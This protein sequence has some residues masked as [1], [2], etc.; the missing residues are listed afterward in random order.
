M[1]RKVLVVTDLHAGSK[2]SVMPDE[3][4]VEGGDTPDQQNC[5]CS[6]GL[7]KILYKEWRKMCDEVGKVDSCITLGDNIDGPNYKSRGF[8]LWTPSLHQQVKTAADLLSE[9]KCPYY[10]YFGVQGSGY[11]VSE[12][13]S[14]DLGVIDCLRG[15][16]G[17]DLT[18]D[19][20]DKRIHCSHVIAPSS[21]PVS[22]ATAPQ[23]EI[24]WSVINVDLFGKLDLIL[25]GHRHEYI[26]LINSKG[27]FIAVPGWKT[28]DAFLTKMGLKA[29]GH[30]IGYTVLE[31][32]NGKDI[33]VDTHVVTLNR[34]QIIKEVNYESLIPDEAFEG[35]LE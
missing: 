9:V 24:M 26:E 33:H 28:R 11:H 19:F 21:S 32:E 17:T 35:D 20:L 16:F 30:E 1:K 14:A 13:S 3:V 4:W 34:D 22:K 27:H 8:E 25:R 7:Q 12:N 18:L 2:F 15:Q 5:I 31:I 6:N 29:A 10:G 23:A